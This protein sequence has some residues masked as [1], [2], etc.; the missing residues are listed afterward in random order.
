MHNVLTVLPGQGKSFSE[1][2]ILPT[3]LV[4]SYGILQ[5]RSLCTPCLPKTVGNPVS[6]ITSNSPTISTVRETRQYCSPQTLLS[7]LTFG[8][9]QIA[10][11]QHSAWLCIEFI[12]SQG[13]G[14][15]TDGEK[16]DLKKGQMRPRGSWVD[17]LPTSA[18]TDVK[19]A[20]S[21]VA[22][23]FTVDLILFGSYF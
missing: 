9:P 22:S 11:W 18:H 1:C 17:L 7:E 6:Q 19:L 15:G 23:H 8:G 5:T 12:Y 21:V 20:T 16:S 4:F 13:W 2:E 3:L 14:K 10:A